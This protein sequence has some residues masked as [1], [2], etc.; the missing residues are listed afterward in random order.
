M[1]FLGPLPGGATDYVPMQVAAA[2]TGNGT[3]LTSIN[4][5]NGG[6]SVATIQVTG[7]FDATVTFEAT[8]DGTNYVSLLMENL[9]T[10]AFTTTVVGTAQVGIFRCTALGL[11]KI[12]AR[13][14]TYASG[15]V[16]AT[17]RLVA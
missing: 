15:T 12:R 17:G 7:T 11:V 14:S 5:T 2:A 6:Y 10:G 16:T 9:T 4:G 1:A 3:V 8:V 13:I